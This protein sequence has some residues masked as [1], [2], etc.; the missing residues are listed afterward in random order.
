MA[1][2]DDRKQEIIKSLK[3]CGE[4]TVASALRFEESKNPDELDAIILGVLAR[5]A[6]NPRP[7]G[8]ASV[9]DDMKLI[10][11]IGMDSFGMIEVVMTA[12][13]VLGLTIATE[14]LRGIIT[15]GDLKKFLRSK[16]GASDS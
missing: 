10:D 5:D 12:E 4:E 8:V 13:E 7:D 2:S 14:D 1:V 15:L 6:A 16:F 9:T 3:R 11:D